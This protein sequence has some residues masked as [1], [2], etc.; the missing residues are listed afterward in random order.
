MRIVTTHT[1][2]R[3]RTTLVRMEAPTASYSSS[4]TRSRDSTARIV[5]ADR[6][7][8]LAQPPGRDRSD[9]LGLREARRAYAALVRLDPDVEWDALVGRCQRNDDHELGRPVVEAVGRDDEL[10]APARLLPSTCRVQFDRPDLPPGYARS[11]RRQSPSRLSPSVASPF[12]AFGQLL[13]PSV[14]DQRQLGVRRVRLVEGTTSVVPRFSHHVG[15]RPLSAAS[16][17][18]PPQLPC[19]FARSSLPLV[20]ETVDEIVT[21]L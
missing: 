8:T 16:S 18:E 14:R 12:R 3:G 17:R 19:R 7:P 4:S 20:H 21:T 13:V 9:V 2:P 5:S 1:H 10:G 11:S 6:T 15:N